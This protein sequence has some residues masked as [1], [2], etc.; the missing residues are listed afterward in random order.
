MN[1]RPECL[2]CC[3]RRVLHAADRTT[4]DDWLRRRVVIDAMKELSRADDKTTPAELMHAVFRRAAKALGDADPY[5]EEKRRWLEESLASEDRIRAQ[6]Q[7]AADPI[8]A[9]VRLAIAANALDWELRQDFFRTVTMKS[10]LD[11][12]ES[13][14]LELDNLDD[15]KAAVAAAKNVL[16]IHKSAGELVF[17]R[18]L[19]ETLRLPGVSLT[20]AV[21]QSPVLADA[22]VEDARAAGLDRVATVMD[23]GGDCLG[24]PLSLCSPTFIEAYRRAD[25]VIAKGQAAFETL[26]GKSSRIDGQE[27]QIFF[28][29]RVKCALMARTVG[30]NVGDGVLERG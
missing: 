17:D 23:V 29:F 28:L 19:L 27:K 2:P 6:I 4:S 22:T 13:M 10:L 5:A 20:T 18:L 3:L 24:V 12:A 14:P 26:E 25:L 30:G 7:A 9:A 15:F 21:R 8:L 16:L 11:G 1:H